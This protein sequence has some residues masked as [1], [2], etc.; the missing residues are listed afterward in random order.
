MASDLKWRFGFGWG[1]VF[2]FAIGLLLLFGTDGPMRIL[3]AVIALASGGYGISQYRKWNSSPWRQVHFR[4]MM[5]YSGI[6]GRHAE[7]A[8][9]GDRPY[10]QLAACRELAL[11][12]VG[13]GKEAN[14]DAMIEVLAQEQGR[15]LASLLRPRTG[16]LFK[17][18][19]PLR[20]DKILAEVEQLEFGPQLV[21]C[22]II[23]NTYGVEQAA[24]YA[25]AICS[26]DAH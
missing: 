19:D 3:G 14:V 23:E 10:D 1:T 24:H 17:D 8:S 5:L 12:V 2:V 16:V 4:G 15:Y 21:L 11:T 7:R 13:P 20:R 22:N 25:F 6:A 9:A 18:L 26:G